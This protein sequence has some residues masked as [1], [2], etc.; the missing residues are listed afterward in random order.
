MSSKPTTACKAA[1]PETCR[2][3]GDPILRE[4]AK[5]DR[6]AAKSAANA[7]RVQT[8]KDSKKDLNHASNLFTAAAAAY[9]AG[10]ITLGGFKLAELAGLTG[11]QQF[12]ALQGKSQAELTTLLTDLI[13][14]ITEEVS[15]PKF[16]LKVAPGNQNGSDLEVYDAKGNFT[17]TSIELKFGDKTD[18]AMGLWVADHL[19]PSGI[20]FPDNAVRTVWR[21]LWHDGESEKQIQQH[22]EALESVYNRI[23]SEAADFE[24]TE[25]AQHILTSIHAGIH[26]KA[27]I[28]NT[29]QKNKRSIIV[30]VLEK[31]KWISQ[32]KKPLSGTWKLDSVNYVKK[33]NRLTLFYRNG[34]DLIKFVLNY[35]NNY[36]QELLDGTI[37]KVPALHGLGSIAF[38]VWVTETDSTPIKTVDLAED[39]NDKRTD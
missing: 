31:F 19:L 11:N 34:A 9:S 6:M 3:H 25:Y 22:R 15:T 5:Q 7:A 37:Q 13:A 24:L 32:T 1:N 14:R 33:T 29:F 17:N 16:T 4:K 20:S 21:K 27:E 23:Q 12:I 30:L 39:T 36:R 10:D 8:N 26:S 18:G 35:K 28:K 38:N 2:Y